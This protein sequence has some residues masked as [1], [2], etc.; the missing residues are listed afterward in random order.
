MKVPS[1]KAQS[2][3][4]DGTAR[5]VPEEDFWDERMGVSLLGGAVGAAA[6]FQNLGI[7]IP[8]VLGICC[9]FKDRL[10]PPSL[11]WLCV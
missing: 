8:L 10:Q 2:W 4:W 9:K 3:A 1:K 11:I 5:S 6:F 7:P